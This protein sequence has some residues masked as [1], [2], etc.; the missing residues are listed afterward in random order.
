[1]IFSLGKLQSQNFSISGKI[2][3]KTAP[4]SDAKV[5]SLEITQGTTSE[6]SGAFTQKNYKLKS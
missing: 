3:L 4:I 6:A 2:L 5:I 1:M